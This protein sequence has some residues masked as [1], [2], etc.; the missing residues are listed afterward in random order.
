MY[1]IKE[2]HKSFDVDIE[3]VD[4][5]GTAINHAFYVN[6]SE[7]GAYNDTYCQIS[8]ESIKIYDRSL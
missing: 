4:K 3:D 7:F 2:R 6:S 5:P 8:E 1:L